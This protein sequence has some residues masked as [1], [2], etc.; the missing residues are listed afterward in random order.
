MGRKRSVAQEVIVREQKR[1]R[2]KAVKL[3]NG[4]HYCPRCRRNSIETDF[5][6]NRKGVKITEKTIRP[7]PSGNEIVKVHLAGSICRSCGEK[8]LVWLLPGEELIDLY[9][10][11]HDRIQVDVRIRDMME[12]LFAVPQDS[13][14]D[15]RKEAKRKEEAELEKWR[16]E[17]PVITI[18]DKKEE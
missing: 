4:W 5:V 17:A 13:A 2:A 6:M 16:K 14:E 3:L 15:R 1:R 8:E 7:G 12:W 9:H 18:P 11:L 10:I